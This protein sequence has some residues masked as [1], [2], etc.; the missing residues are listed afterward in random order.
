M[1]MINAI[2]NNRKIEIE[3]PS[4]LPDGS[5]VSVLVVGLPTNSDLMS[6][7]EIASTVHAMDLFAAAFPSQLDGEDLSAAARVAGELEKKAFFE[8]ADKLARMFD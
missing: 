6:A 4:E 8:N 5:P 2:V 7:E 1:N 3:A